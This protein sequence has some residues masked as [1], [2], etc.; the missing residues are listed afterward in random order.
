MTRVAPNL[1]A[2]APNSGC[3]APQTN[4]PIASAK[5]IDTMP[6]PVAVLIGD[7]N[8]P[9]DCRAPIVIIRIAADASSSGHCD[10]LFSWRCGV[11]C[12]VLMRPP[13]AGPSGG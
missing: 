5:L 12:V 1:S 8:R 13:R 9:V 6:R 2:T 11:A 10:R 4:W 7:R 3:A